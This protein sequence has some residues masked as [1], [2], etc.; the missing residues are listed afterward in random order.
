VLWFKRIGM[1]LGVIAAAAGI[2]Y[3][4]LWKY[5]ET[6]SFAPGDPGQ[7]QLAEEYAQCA[8]YYRVM[9]SSLNKEHPDYLE[10]ERQYTREFE[11]HIK[12]GFNFS[13]D[14]A[15]F[16][17]RVEKA[18]SRFA[19]EVRMAANTENVLELVDKKMHQC[20]DVFFRGAAFVERKLQERNK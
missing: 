14:K 3:F 15:L 7:A 13:P 11:H 12:M 17:A 4:A 20:F 10:Q 2:A 16:K 8:G 19:D 9:L 5:A 6:Y 18:S 1:T